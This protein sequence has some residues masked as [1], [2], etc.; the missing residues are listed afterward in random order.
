MTG[1]LAEL[2]EV[3]RSGRVESFHL[4]AAVVVDA[5]GQTL[6][7][8]GPP[9][10]STYLRSAA[11][12]FQLLTMLDLGLERTG[13]FGGHEL[14]VCAASHGGEP[15][16]VAT[17]RGLL[18]RAGLGEELLQCGGHWPLDD[19]ARE[20]LLRNGCSAPL[21]IYNNCSGKHAAM[22]ITC[23]ANGWP[24]ASYLEPDHPLQAHVEGVVAAMAGERPGIG[25]DGCGVPTYFL[26]LASTA[27]AVA[28]LMAL[29]GEEGAA[30]RVVQAMTGYPWFTSGTHR[31][32]Y[33]LMRVCP[34]LLAKEGAEGFFA[35]GIPADRSPWAVPVGF[36]MKVFDG[37][38]EDAR[39]REPA[40]ASALLSL[41]LVR[42]T[43]RPALEA[44]ATQP[45]RTVAGRVV[46]ELRGVLRLRP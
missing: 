3:H 10:F 30:R 22:L 46:G 41:G 19:L 7:S 37:A 32:A 12:P 6:A 25:A 2:T 31:L 13:S 36:V 23:V 38:G 39:G 45:L 28:A 5:T 34:G 35:V 18:A 20:T 42:D 24:L 21:P 29:A 1:Q 44:L 33:N 16:H 40:V 11:K 26:S 27:R 14:A 9:D 17:V 15:E 8:A 43:E 4:G